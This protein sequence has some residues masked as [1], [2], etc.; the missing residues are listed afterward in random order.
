MRSNKPR[1]D[2]VVVSYNSARTLPGCL[3][4]LAGEPSLGV[5]VVDNASCDESVGVAESLSVPVIALPTNRG[6]AGGCNVGWRAGQA[7]DVLFLNPDASMT[8]DGVLRLATARERLAAGAIAPR[9]VD[10]AGELEWSLRRFPTVRSIYGQAFFAHR[11]F[12]KARWVD[13]VIRDQPQYEREA[14]CDWASGACLLVR[15]NLLE[16]LDGF[17]DGFF[18]YR[19]DVDLCRRLWDA[20]SSVMYTP[21]VT[22]THAGGASAPR[23]RLLRVLARS[24]IRY[25]RKHFR[26]PASATYRVGVGASA[27]THLLAG[28]GF[29]RRYGHALALLATIGFNL[30]I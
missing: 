23:W 12:P 5:V 3:M 27:F 10:P 26:R 8:P 17:D 1:V 7:R 18:L 11:L 16:Q 2:V 14:P 20:G 9:V 22:C 21:S 28:R 15:R 13:E 6:F 29:A 30:Q 4:P 24:R 19:E 25:A